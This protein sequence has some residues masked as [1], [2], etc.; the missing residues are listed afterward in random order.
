MSDFCR[1]LRLSHTSSVWT[2]KA[3]VRLRGC[4][5]SPELSLVAC[6]IST[7]IS[8]AGSFFTNEQPHEQ[9]DLD[10][11]VVTASGAFCYFSDAPYSSLYSVSKQNI[12]WASSWQNQQNDCAASE[13]T[14]QPGHPPSLIRVFAVRMKEDWVLNYP[15]SAQRRFWSDW[16]DAQA[17]LSLRWAHM[18]FR[19]FYHEAAHK[20]WNKV[21]HKSFV[22]YF[23]RQ[24][25]IC[26][27]AMGVMVTSILTWNKCI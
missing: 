3:L 23:T 18:P 26:T 15:M 19:W 25:D 7:I 1:T 13:D 17:D 2:A 4:A 27:L 20:I 12:K 5:G 6:V 22:I 8:W 14:D 9:R 10:V 21:K 24:K 11:V 16:E